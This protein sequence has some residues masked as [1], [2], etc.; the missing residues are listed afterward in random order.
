[1]KAQ[2]LIHTHRLLFETRRYFEHEG[3]VSADAFAAYDAQPIRP[4]HFHR[5]KEAHLGAIEL[6]LEG[7]DTRP[8]VP[9]PA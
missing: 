2:E 4:T 5:G 6:L 3:T 1:M 9:S 8:N 7:L